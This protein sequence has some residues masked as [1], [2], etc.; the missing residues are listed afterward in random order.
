MPT[1]EEEEEEEEAGIVIGADDSWQIREESFGGFFYWHCRLQDCT[2]H[3]AEG[4]SSGKVKTLVC[5]FSR[6][7]KVWQLGV[8]FAK[9]ALDI[10]Y[11]VDAVKLGASTEGL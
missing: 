7:K 4:V 5:M 6:R 1:K 10:V 3:D 11:S 2:C 9:M 8:A